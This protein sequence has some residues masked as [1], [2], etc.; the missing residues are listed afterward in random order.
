MR[1]RQFFFRWGH[2]RSCGIFGGERQERDRGERAERGRA[3]TGW[4]GGTVQ[5]W[6]YSG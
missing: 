5:A 6:K 2:V 3:E 1:R 4:R